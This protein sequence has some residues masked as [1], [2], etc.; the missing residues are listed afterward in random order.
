MTEAAIQV[1][2]VFPGI[3]MAIMA[4]LPRESDVLEMSD[5]E[6][7]LALLQSMDAVTWAILLI[8]TIILTIFQIILLVT[9][10]QTI[11]KKIFGI[12]I[13]KHDGTNPGFWHIAILRMILPALVGLVPVNLVAFL[14]PLVDALFIFSK[15]HRCLHDRIAGTIV[16][17]V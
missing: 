14:F 5:E 4:L 12:R 9:N 8:P 13:A 17:N 2:I 6:V 11:G 3:V 15:G 10:G 7:V 16:V 1:A